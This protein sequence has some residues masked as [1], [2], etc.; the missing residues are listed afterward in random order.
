MSRLVRHLG[1]VLFLA[2][3]ACEGANPSL[4][5]AQTTKRPPAGAPST[6]LPAPDPSPQAIA[7]SR[8]T[9]ITEAVARVAPAVVTVQTETCNASPPRPFEQ[10]FGGRS[11][12]QVQ[13]GASAPASSFAPTA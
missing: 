6:Q 13:P 10:F 1:P 4:S 9:A 7:G 3:A 11:G 2:L 12:Q 8:R 5:D